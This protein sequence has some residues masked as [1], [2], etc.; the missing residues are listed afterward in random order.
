MANAFTTKLEAINTILQIIDEEP[1]NSLNDELPLEATTAIHNLEEVSREIQSKGYDFNTEYEFPLPPNLDGTITLPQSTL[2]F[3]IPK[4]SINGGGIDYIQRG[5]RVYNRTDRTF[6][7]NKTLKAM[8]VS[9][10]NWDDLPEQFRKWITIRAA[11]I[12]AARTVGDQATVS[13]SMQ[14]EIEAKANAEN[15]DAR[16]SNATIFDNTISQLITNRN[17]RRGGNLNY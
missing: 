5:V 16:S 13:F 7:I 1:I 17:I 4:Q 3:D 6:I 10:L 9:F 8:V 14:E 15:S 11:R 12:T 2:S